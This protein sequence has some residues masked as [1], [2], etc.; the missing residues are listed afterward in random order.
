MSKKGEDNVLVMPSDHMILNNDIFSEFKKELYI[1]LFLFFTSSVNRK[2]LN[3]YEVREFKE[4]PILE[5]AKEY[6]KNGYY[7]NA[8]IFLFNTKLFTEEVKKETRIYIIPS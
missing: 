5:I 7:W 4:K 3:G 8:G 2:I 6:V 1:F